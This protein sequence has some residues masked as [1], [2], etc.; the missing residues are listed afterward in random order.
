MLNDNHILYHGATTVVSEPLTSVG[1]YDLDLGQG[2]YVTN[3][4]SQA[5]KWAMAI[6]KLLISISLL[7]RLLK[8]KSYSYERLYFIS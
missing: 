8:Y 6:R 2:F 7:L 4:R 3:D 5:E 1:R